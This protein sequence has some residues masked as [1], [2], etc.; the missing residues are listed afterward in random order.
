MTALGYEFYLLL[1]I[2]N[3]YWMRLSMISCIIIKGLFESRLNF[4]K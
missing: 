4:L 3:N 1:Q 2:I